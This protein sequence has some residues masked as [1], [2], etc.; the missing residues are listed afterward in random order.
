MAGAAL[1]FFLGL[2]GAPFFSEWSLNSLLLAVLLLAVLFLRFEEREPGSRELAAVGLLAA[3]AAG[4]RVLF[5]AV[6]GLQ[7]ATFLTIAAG[8][9]LGAEPGFMVGALT[10]LLS[11]IFLGHGPWTPWQMLGWGLAGA[12]GGLMGKAFRGRV[13]VPAVAGLGTAW[14]F[15][16]GWGMNLWFWLSFVRPLTL[17]SFTAACAASLPFDLLHA[18]GNL[19]F[20]LLLAGPVI[21]MLI[22]FRERFSCEFEEASAEAVLDGRGTG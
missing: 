9:A 15:L 5:A 3:L 2:R 16:F 13:R 17:R 6:P 1:A 19:F 14:G 12:A 7:P 22:R 10:A 4:G 8:Y 11:N 18:A 20:A 21:D